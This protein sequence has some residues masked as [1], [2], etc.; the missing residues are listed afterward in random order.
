MIRDGAGRDRDCPPAI[1]LGGGREPGAALGGGTKD[2]DR[3][4][5]AALGAHR[6]RHQ[7]FAVV[8]KPCW[9]ELRPMGRNLIS[10]TAKNHFT[11]VAI[12]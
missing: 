4:A 10:P 9:L 5:A 7:H 6:I 8:R 1:H 11:T 12:C 2:R 3:R